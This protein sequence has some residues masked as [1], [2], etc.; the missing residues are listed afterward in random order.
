MPF[1][2]LRL[3]WSRGAVRAPS[4][5]ARHHPRLPTNRHAYR[6]LGNVLPSFPSPHDLAVMGDD[7]RGEGWRRGRRRHA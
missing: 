2:V 3:A 7:K 4:R 1:G 6:P 5:S